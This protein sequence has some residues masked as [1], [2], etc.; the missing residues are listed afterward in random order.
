MAFPLWDE[1][2]AKCHASFDESDPEPWRTPRFHQL[3]VHNVEL[4]VDCVTCHAS[5]EADGNPDHAFLN[6]TRVRSQCALCH[7]EFEEGE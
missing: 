5:H 1:D 6:A 7:P 2:C 3:A 4:G